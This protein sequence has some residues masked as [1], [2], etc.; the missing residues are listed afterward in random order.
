MLIRRR[1][2]AQQLKRFAAGVP[3]LVLLAGQ[4]GDS[5]ASFDVADFTINANAPGAM[6]DIINFLGLDMIMLLRAAAGGQPR[7]GQALVANGR[8]AVREQLPDFRAILGSERHDVVQVFDVHKFG[9]P[10]NELSHKY[11]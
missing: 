5:I 6:G 9:L 3:Q 11:I 7:F 2:T 8:I 4:N 1:A 10:K